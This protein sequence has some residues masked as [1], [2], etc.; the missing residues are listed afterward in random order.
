MFFLHR[1]Y[2]F[3]YRQAD[4]DILSLFRKLSKPEIQVI[5]FHGTL[6]RYFDTLLRASEYRFVGP[7]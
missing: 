5:V 3:G 7:E 1:L 2:F 6:K 4:G